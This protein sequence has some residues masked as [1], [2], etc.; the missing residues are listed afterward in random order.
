MN[1]NNNNNN[2]NGCWGVYK[3]SSGK[4]IGSDMSSGLFVIKTN[5]PMT[6]TSNYSTS[7][8]EQFSLE[9][10][11][12]NPFNPST[13]IRFSLK[14]NSNVKLSIFDLKGAEVAKLVNDRR[15]AGNYEVKFDAAKHGLTS[16]TYFY[17]MDIIG[18]NGR[19]SETKKMILTK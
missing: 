19:Y 14:E 7:N 12:P 8:P 6:G 1:P 5:F 15:D 16:G 4:I 2:F 18:F 9:Q 3:F 17:R 11:Y 13:S 10:N